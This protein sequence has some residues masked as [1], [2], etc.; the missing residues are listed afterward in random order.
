MS[1]AGRTETEDEQPSAAMTAAI[2]RFQRHHPG[3]SCV[4]CLTAV[5]QAGVLDAGE[6]LRAAV[7]AQG[8]AQ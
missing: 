4:D 5:Y 2:I 1:D 6:A 7:G 3:H 8:E